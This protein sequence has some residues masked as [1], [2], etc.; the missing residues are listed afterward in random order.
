MRALQSLNAVFASINQFLVRVCPAGMFDNTFFARIHLLFFMMIIM[1][2]VVGL[3]SWQNQ[4]RVDDVLL[5]GTV[6]EAIVTKTTITRGKSTTYSI[7]IVW[8]DTQGAQ[9]RLD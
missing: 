2:P 8:H 1:G 9:R 5:R 6:A 7:D 4:R 3:I